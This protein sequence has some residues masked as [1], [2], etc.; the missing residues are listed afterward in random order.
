MNTNHHSFR[1]K[2]KGRA[3]ALLTALALLLPLCSQ[4]QDWSG[5]TPR[6][7][8]RGVWLTTLGGLDWPR[9]AATTAEGFARQREELCSTLDQL[10]AA[11]INTVFFQARI[12]S[13][14]AY[15]S[16]IEPW[17]GAF[18][19]T[20]G[21]AP[22]YDPLRLAVDECHKRGME[23]HAWVVAFPIC[24]VAVAKRLGRKALPNL[25]PE[26]CKRAGDQWMMNPGVPETATYIASICKE[27]AE[28][29]D[30]DGI[31][32]DYI[33]YPEQSIPWNDRATFRK[34]GKKGQSL[35]EWRTENVTRCVRAIH[36]AVKG[37]RPWI[38]MSCSPVGKHSDLP[39]QSSYGWNAR[40]AV[41]QDAQA[42]L[43][44]GLMDMLC[45][46]MYFD[47]KHFY[48]F[49]L[50]WKENSA[51][52]PVVPGLGIYF[53]SPREKDW[54]LDVVR[55]QIYFIRQAQLG[56]EAYFRSK[57]LTD[58]V[59]GLYSCLQ[60]EIYRQPSLIPPMTWADSVAPA[61]PQGARAERN[62]FTLS[63][64]WQAVGDPTPVT[65]RI[66]RL[67]PA[68]KA[69]AQ[70]ST[71]SCCGKNRQQ[72]CPT[73][74]SRGEKE[75]SQGKIDFSRGKETLSRE[76][77]FPSHYEVK[78]V[79]DRIKSTHYELTPPLPSQLHSRYAV[80]AV[81]AYGNESPLSAL[82]DGSDTETCSEEFRGYV[83]T[84]GQIA[85]PADAPESEYL[86]VCDLSGRHVMTLRRTATP[87]LSALAPGGYELRTL[88]RKGISHRLML[89][90]KTKGGKMQ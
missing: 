44:D 72:E 58:N 36:D 48:P 86:L 26:L 57:F 85:L 27:I 45:P 37:V 50:D 16:A 32:L 61:R 51:G 71:T 17:D 23:L 47:G 41:N 68:C 75:L 13:T 24:K 3:A 87:D 73:E 70:N 28:N 90:W 2:I 78:L 84:E 19:G 82:S 6:Y 46:M 55:R 53:L 89:I 5:R 40:E 74:L 33:R 59:K 38:K 11:G 77:N 83:V 54:D 76:K 52:R 49:A 9:R 56:G 4:A 62:G 35:A 80:V 34:Y 10:K 39:R 25:H 65:Y 7:E 21:R 67:D 1:N 60:T 15:P 12:R 43:R 42:W 18:T 20:P 30:V 79:A 88:A 29:Y 31:H 81:D 69:F 66:Y 8:V 14:T 63:M 22:D 64:A